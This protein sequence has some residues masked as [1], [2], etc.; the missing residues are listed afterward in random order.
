MSFP[1]SPQKEEALVGFLNQRR[2]IEGP[3]EILRDVHPQEFKAGDPFNL[4]P[5]DVHG[6]VS[7]RP[8]PPEVHYYLFGLL[9]VQCHRPSS[10]TEK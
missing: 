2:G 7:D 6:S 8:S 1:Q 3:G 5:V 9:G 10:K 4:F